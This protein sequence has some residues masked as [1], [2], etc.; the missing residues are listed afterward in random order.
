MASPNNQGRLL[1]EEDEDSFEEIDMIEIS[2]EDDL[3]ATDQGDLG[4][5]EIEDDDEG[6][7]GPGL[8]GFSGIKP[9]YILTAHMG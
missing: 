5:D 9:D 4:D 6:P 2:D 3:Q 1:E 8:E 7:F